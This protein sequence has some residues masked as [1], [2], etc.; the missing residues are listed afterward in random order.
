LPTE[1]TSL[2]KDKPRKQESKKRSF[3]TEQFQEEASM[4]KWVAVLEKTSA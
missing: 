4:P 3:A 2:K 1:T